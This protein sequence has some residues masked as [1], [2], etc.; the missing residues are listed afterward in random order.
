M[1]ALFIYHTPEYGE[2][3]AKLLQYVTNLPKYSRH[4]TP[5]NLKLKI[6]SRNV[7]ANC[8]NSNTRRT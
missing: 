5:L 1:V 2:S 4:I 8:W 6:D 7:M 3:A